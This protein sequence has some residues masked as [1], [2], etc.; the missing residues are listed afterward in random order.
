VA[1]HSFTATDEMC[2]AQPSCRSAE[3]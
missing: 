3:L 2:T 1:A